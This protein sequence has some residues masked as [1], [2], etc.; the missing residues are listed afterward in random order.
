MP[1]V[2]FAMIMFPIFHNSPKI[3][4]H[5]MATKQ[6][7]VSFL[8]SILRREAFQ[9]RVNIVDL[10]IIDVE[11]ID[12]RNQSFYLNYIIIQRYENIKFHFK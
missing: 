9:L 10:L 1:H 6:R 12:T 4:K 11:T 7:N 2:Q 8:R 5:N 3:E